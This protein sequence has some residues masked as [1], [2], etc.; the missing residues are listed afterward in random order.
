MQN[1]TPNLQKT[2]KNNDSIAD[3]FVSLFFFSLIKSLDNKCGLHFYLTLHN[4]MSSPSSAASLSL[5]HLSALLMTC[6]VW[7]NAA[8]TGK[9]QSVLNTS[10]Q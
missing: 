8:L 3:V 9:P 7:V 10:T 2:E 5:L 6:A 4:I 1:S